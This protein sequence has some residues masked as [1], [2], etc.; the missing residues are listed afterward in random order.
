MCPTYVKFQ[1][2]VAHV[3]V[4]VLLNHVYDMKFYRIT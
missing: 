4:L 2:A 3:Q 1:P